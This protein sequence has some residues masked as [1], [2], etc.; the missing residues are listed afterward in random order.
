MENVIN[1]KYSQI[2]GDLLDELQRL[3]EIALRKG[4]RQKEIYVWFKSAQQDIIDS[5]IFTASI[6]SPLEYAKQADLS[7]Y[8]LEGLLRNTLLRLKRKLSN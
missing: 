4:F 2:K 8:S 1:R 3:L 5:F 6:T 7:L